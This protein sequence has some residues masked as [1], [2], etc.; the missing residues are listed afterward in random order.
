MAKLAVEGCSG[1][2]VYHHRLIRRRIGIDEYGFRIRCA[3]KGHRTLAFAENQ[4]GDLELFGGILGAHVI[5]RHHRAVGK[6]GEIVDR[7]HGR[8]QRLRRPVGRI[9]PH[10][11]GFGAYPYVCRHG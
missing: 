1:G 2:N 10:S 8:L 11:A 3:E 9:V 7:R 4:T 6:P 5:V